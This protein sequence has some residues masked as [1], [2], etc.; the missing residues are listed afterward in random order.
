VWSKRHTYHLT[1]RFLGDQIAETRVPELEGELNAVRSAPF[2][3]RLA[4]VGRF[5]PTPNKPARVLWV[6]MD[7]PSALA[8]LYAQ[9]ENTVTRIGF[10]SD[11][12]P[13]SP[14]ITLARL[15]IPKPNPQVD[16]FLKKFAN[17]TTDA[18]PVESF[19]L[20]SS[21]LS[22]QGPAYTKIGTFPLRAK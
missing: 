20:I 15:K 13:F 17:F 12:H 11:D 3:V 8:T 7:A 10:P 14:H 1:L 22:P 21:V 2:N 5:P 6:G 19:H 9:V 16:Q 18:I 4:S